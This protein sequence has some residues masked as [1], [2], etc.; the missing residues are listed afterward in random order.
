MA[1]KDFPYIRR[2]NGAVDGVKDSKAAFQDLLNFVRLEAPDLLYHA[3]IIKPFSALERPAR[4]P[5]NKLKQNTTHTD[6]PTNMGGYSAESSG[7]GLLAPLPPLCQRPA[8]QWRVGR[9]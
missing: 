5:G 8:V 7:R 2:E 4:A 1:T 3:P 6:A 9:S